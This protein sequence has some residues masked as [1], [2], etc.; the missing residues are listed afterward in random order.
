MK[1]SARCYAV[2]GLAYSPPWSVNAGF[3][4]GEE[5][6]LIVDTGGNGAACGAGS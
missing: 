4:T 6:T 3:I 5:V 1:I 2:T